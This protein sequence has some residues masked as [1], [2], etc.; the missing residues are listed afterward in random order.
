MLVPASRAVEQLFFAGTMKY[1]RNRNAVST[2]EGIKQL[3]SRPLLLVWTCKVYQTHPP[4]DIGIFRFYWEA[5][6]T[7]PTF[8][9]GETLP[10]CN[11]K[12]LKV[13]AVRRRCPVPG[14]WNVCLLIRCI[15]LFLSRLWTYKMQVC[16]SLKKLIAE[17]NIIYQTA[18]I[19]VATFWL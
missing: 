5:K 11:A 18:Q 14:S 7:I 15:I 10:N 9:A 1:A 2:P 8:I 19:S 4:A 17:L 6:M 3:V 12:Q 16:K 13:R